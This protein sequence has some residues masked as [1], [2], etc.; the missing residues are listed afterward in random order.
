M[1]EAVEVSVCGGFNFY[2]L[3][4]LY[5]FTP[6]VCGLCGL[7]SLIILVI[8]VLAAR[9]RR[10]DGVVAPATIGVTTLGV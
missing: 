8:A 4:L 6:L 3:V 10:E 1:S 7:T 9:C 5:V 2:L